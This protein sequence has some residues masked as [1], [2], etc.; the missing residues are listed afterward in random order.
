MSDLP[1]VENTPPPSAAAAAK[2]TAAP[3]PVPAPNSPE[4]LTPEEQ[5]ERFAKQL[6]EDDWGHQPC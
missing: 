5:M 6:K 2:G 3:A 4:S 1:P